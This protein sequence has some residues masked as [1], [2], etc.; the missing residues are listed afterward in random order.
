MINY[1]RQVVDGFASPPEGSPKDLIETLGGQNTYCDVKC[2]VT[3]CI[4]L[5]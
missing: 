2:V 3:F 5:I 4:S 1:S